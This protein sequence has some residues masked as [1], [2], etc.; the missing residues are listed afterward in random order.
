[1]ADLSVLLNV[2]V[3]AFTLTA[4]ALTGLGAL[5]WRRSGQARIGGLSL[6]FGFFAVAGIVSAVWLFTSEDLERLLTV[7]LA[8]TAL[9]LLAIYAAA[10]KR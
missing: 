3:A 7:H 5:A 10:V 4:L 2:A 8:V 6:G 1:M 9:G